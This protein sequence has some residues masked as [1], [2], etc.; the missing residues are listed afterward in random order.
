MIDLKMDA[1]AEIRREFKPIATRVPGIQIC[2]HHPRLPATLV[3]WVG[4]RSLVGSEG[5][6]DAFQCMTG[7]THQRHPAGGFPSLGSVV[8]KVQGSV[9][10]AVPPFVS[11][12]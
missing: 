5:R 8:S 9:Q 12:S 6:H 10:P 7:W 3:K 1:P 11:L 2:E 4:I